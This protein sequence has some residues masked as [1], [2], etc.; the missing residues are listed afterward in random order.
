V[1]Y[2]L[3]LGLAAWLALAPAPARAESLAREAGLGASA[4]LLNLLYGPGKLVYAA[5]GSLVAG[6]A[7]LFSAGDADVA[8]PVLTAALRGDYVVTPEHLRGEKELEFF[9]REANDAQR[10]SAET[11]PVS[12][13]DGLDGATAEETPAESDLTD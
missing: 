8:G 13:G 7:W 4:A 11:P 12:S 10:A 6:G 5:L 2:G 9:G 3:A 1:S